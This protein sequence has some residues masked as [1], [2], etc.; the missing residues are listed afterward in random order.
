MAVNLTTVMTNRPRARELGIRIGRLL[1][2]GEL[3]A[4]TDVPRVKVGMSE[5]F[6]GNIDS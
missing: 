3:N 4:I 1:S 6:L 2:P 5:K